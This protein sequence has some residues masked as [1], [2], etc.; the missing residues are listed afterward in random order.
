MQLC[1]RGLDCSCRG[2]SFQH[3]GVKLAEVLL[4]LWNSKF[5]WDAKAFEFVEVF[6]GAEQCSKAWLLDYNTENIY[7]P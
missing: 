6:S 2:L 4:A 3:H 1:S 7:G 5:N